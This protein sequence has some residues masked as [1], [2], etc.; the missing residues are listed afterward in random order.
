LKF[1][2]GET[3]KTITVSI[4]NDVYVENAETFTVTLSSPVGATLGATTT[5]TITI[6]DNA[7]G[8]EGGTLI[9]LTMPSF[10]QTALHR[11]SES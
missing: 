5:A 1:A 3:T 11:F 4:I 6:N 2:A 7:G 10:C 8:G 9:R